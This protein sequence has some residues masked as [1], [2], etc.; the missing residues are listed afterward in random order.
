M[1]V[2]LQKSLANKGKEDV[3][4]EET[5]I[6]RPLAGKKGITLLLVLL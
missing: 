4:Q 6:P 1:L 3:G 2:E 5:E